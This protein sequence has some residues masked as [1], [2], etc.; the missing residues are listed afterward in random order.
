MILITNL[1]QVAASIVSSITNVILSIVI[2]VISEKLLRPNT[3]PKEYVFI[4]WGVLIS[5]YI[6][7]AIP[8]ALNANIFGV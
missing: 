4:F 3:I 1:L 6:N 7:S 5:N 2:A 8:L